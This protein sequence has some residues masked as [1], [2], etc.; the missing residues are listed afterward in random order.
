LDTVK[1]AV[2]PS[3][4]LTLG[5][6]LL[7]LCVLSA[8]GAAL[9][10]R[11]AAEQV[12]H[13][14][15]VEN[16]LNRLGTLFT[17]AETQQRGYLLTGRASYL[18]DYQ[19]VVSQ[20]PR[21]LDDLQKATLDN[22]VQ[23]DN[24]TKLRSAA[25]DKLAELDETIR[26]HGAGRGADALAVVSS[27]RGKIA[28]ARIEQLIAAMEAEEDGLLSE[29]RAAA[30]GRAD[31]AFLVLGISAALVLTL[32]FLARLVGRR[33]IA[34]LEDRNR[35]LHQEIAARTQA[36]SQVR[37]LQKMEAV[38]QLTGGIAHDFNNMLAIIL[39]SLD[40]ARLKLKRDDRG[41]AMK[42]LDHA[43]EGAQRA[44][45]LT[46][47]L[48]A[49][50]RSQPLEPRVIEANRLVQNMSELLRRA[51]GERIQIETVLAG[52]LW[53]IDADPSQ[54]ENALLNLAV[55]A[56]DAMPDGGKL[57]IETGNS[58]LDERYAR[59]HDE[60]R[61]GQYV[62]ISV[63]D[64]GAGMSQDVIE[65]A[66]DPFFTTKGVG[67][68]T[69]LGLS[70]VFGFVKQSNGH[71][72]IYSEVGKGTTVRI[73]L[74][75]YFGPSVSA[76]PETRGT[77]IERARDGETILVAEDDEEVRTM[78]VAM[79]AELGYQ[80]VETGDG[81]QAL[82]ALESRGDITLLF[83]DIVM[84]GMTGRELGDRAIAMKPSLKLLYTTGYTRNAIV[85]NGMV[86][87]G[88][89]F[90]QKP[91]AIEDLA[92]KLRDVIDDT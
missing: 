49:F 60:V 44:A 75:R 8:V 14:L 89:A 47:Q 5:F 19:Q 50:S 9:L 71:V 22:A 54:I 18:G 29:R 41:A 83:T 17:R 1:P 51:L 12:Q 25:S 52:G 30:T 20:L 13:T 32:G 45:A 80:V 33:Y 66:F 27:D 72:K 70:Q 74:P 76:E 15:E 88:V 7:G 53:R 48:L 36:Q 64:T 63:T 78:T 69:G 73:Y 42:S 84:P 87:Q 56:R 91:F 26:L 81:E 82:A 24:V 35:A 79:L 21:Q 11:N 62:M 57:T 77:E 6:A 55:N 85:H 16:R 39:G 68:G 34:A 46:A 58:E 61:A 38:G 23:Q 90:I 59:M 86:D 37:Q 4:L 10:Q 31:L 92:R 43:Q 3:L 40:L 28:M 67:R 65:R 2:K